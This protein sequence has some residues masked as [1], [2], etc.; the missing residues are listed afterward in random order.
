VS[1][2][3]RRGRQ[4]VGIAAHRDG[5]LLAADRS[6]VRGI[7][8]T[9]VARTL[10]DLASLKST[11][12]L[13]SAIA[14]AQRR[15]IFDLHACR[16]LIGRSKGRRGVAIL[17]TFIAQFDPTVAKTRSELERKFLALCRQAGV[18]RPR[19]NFAIDVSG[20]RVLGDFVWPD[21][22]WIVETDGRETHGTPS[23]FES[24]RLRDQR[25]NVAGWRVLRCTW[26]QV[27]T[28]AP[29]LRRTLRTLI[30]KPPPTGRIADL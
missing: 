28:N 8:C 13:E 24:D 4:P 29:E 11:K 3:N 6:R 14:E 9:S 7:P 12:Q 16:E 23:A 5:S 2:P 27:E 10:L 20:G 18:P 26:N 21:R 25:L 15:G 19:V 17:R 1:A 22:R 30:N